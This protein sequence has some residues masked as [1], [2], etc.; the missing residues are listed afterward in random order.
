[1]YVKTYKTGFAI[2]VA[3][4]HRVKSLDDEVVVERVN[5]EREWLQQSFESAKQNVIL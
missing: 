2:T 5:E 1:M 4:S 3:S